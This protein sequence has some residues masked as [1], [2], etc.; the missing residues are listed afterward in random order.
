MTFTIRGHIVPYV[1][2]TQR[3][4]WADPRARNYLDSQAAIR[5]QLTSQLIE[6]AQ[7][8]LPGQTPLMVNIDFDIGKQMHTTDCDNLIKAVIDA[9]Q[10]VVYPNDCWIDEIH[11]TRRQIDNLIEDIAALSV[12]V[13]R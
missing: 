10:E 2:M 6:Q 11:V 4:K 12:I 7:E 9:A 1:R 5:R 13:L 8:M 3:S